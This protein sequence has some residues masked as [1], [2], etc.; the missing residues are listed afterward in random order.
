MFLTFSPFTA[1]KGGCFGGGFLCV[2][3]LDS[4]RDHGSSDLQEKLYKLM[5]H[6]Q[7]CSIMYI[8]RLYYGVLIIWWSHSPPSPITVQQFRMRIRVSTSLPKSFPQRA[9]KSSWLSSVPWQ[10]WKNAWGSLCNVYDWKRTWV[11][12]SPYSWAQ[13]VDNMR[14]NY[15]VWSEK[16]VVFMAGG[17]YSVH[18]LSLENRF[19]F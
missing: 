10:S 4:C 13:Y 9:K 8:H 14:L 3:R 1:L 18:R 2:G 15:L 16:L 5:H 7:I 19:I 12:L 6:V 17:R 11:V